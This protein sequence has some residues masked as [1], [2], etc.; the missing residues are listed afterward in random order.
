MKVIALLATLLP[1]ASAVDWSLTGYSSNNCDSTT[2]VFENGSDGVNFTCQ[3][4]DTTVHSADFEGNNFWCLYLFA[5]GECGEETKYL[6]TGAT[7]CQ[8]GDWGSY[9]FLSSLPTAGDTPSIPTRTTKMET[10]TYIILALLAIFLF[11]PALFRDKSPIPE[12]SGNVHKIT[13]AAE[14]D[15][16]LRS[17]SNVVVD[18]YADWCPPCRSIAPVFSGLADK[19]ALKGHLAFA[20]VNVDHVNDVAGRYGVSAMPTFVFFEGAKPTPVQAKLPRAAGPSVVVVDGGVERIRGADPVSL[21]AVTAALY[22]KVK[23]AAGVVD[24]PADEK[25]SEQS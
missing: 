1:A 14:L 24:A 25:A 12:T 5:D 6:A 22:E 18:F 3:S 20:K 19:H 4:F 11:G 10:S 16:L 23:G 7:G 2:T 15:A 9:S 21:T 13:K 8:V 17:T